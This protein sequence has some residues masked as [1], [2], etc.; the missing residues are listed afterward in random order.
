MRRKRGADVQ[1]L[2][3]YFCFSLT[4]VC[5]RRFFPVITLGYISIHAVV[6]VGRVTA[7]YDNQDVHLDEF[8]WASQA[9]VKFQ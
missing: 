3:R 4:N 6:V 5:R 9:T 1:I 8:Y 2:I 7:G